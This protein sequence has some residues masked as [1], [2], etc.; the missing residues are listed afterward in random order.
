MQSFDISDENV[1][2]KQYKLILQFKDFLAAGNK[3]SHNTV[4]NYLSDIRHLLGYMQSYHPTSFEPLS[5]ST[6]IIL[7]YK[8]SMM[9]SGT[10]IITIKRRL[11]SIQR[12]V[13]FLGIESQS[14]PETNPG[15][16]DEEESVSS[17]QMP[18]EITGRNFYLNAIMQEYIKDRNVSIES[19]NYVRDFLLLVHS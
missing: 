2:Y 9:S 10:S 6:R 17:N 16:S 4:K 15:A 3:Y 19:K 12:F 8:Q 13:E 1:V 14:V 18:Y 5:V 11:S 7:K